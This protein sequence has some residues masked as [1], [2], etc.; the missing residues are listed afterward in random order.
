M[1]HIVRASIITMSIVVALLTMAIIGY[2][3]FLVPHS[4]IYTYE[5]LRAEEERF[6][7]VLEQASDE[8]KFLVLRYAIYQNYVPFI[9]CDVDPHE[10][11]NSVISKWSRTKQIYNA[12]SDNE[13]LLCQIYPD[14]NALSRY[15]GII[16]MNE[17]IM[18]MRARR[19][20]PPTDIDVEQMRAEIHLNLAKD[21]LLFENLNKQ[22][23][24]KNSLVNTY[25][26][27]PSLK[28]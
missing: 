3:C 27:T 19:G 26:G 1:K 25:F 28:N 2:R 4:G 21:S 24:K 7:K 22:S 15:V 5:S 18:E 9:T 20:L 8:E 13:E 17:Y 11:I 6:D 23:R 12:L 14:L 16:Q 10:N